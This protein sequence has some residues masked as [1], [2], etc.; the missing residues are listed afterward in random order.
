[1]DTAPSTL[2]ALPGVV[3]AAGG[4]I[5]VLF[6]GGIRRGTDIVKALALGASAILIGRPYIYGL[7]VA[8]SAG[9]ARVVEILLDE[10]RSAMALCGTPTLRSLNQSVLWNCSGI[11]P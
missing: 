2:E 6:D 10:L 1:L 3:Q 4:K 11:K 9:V 5:P 8:G 7:T